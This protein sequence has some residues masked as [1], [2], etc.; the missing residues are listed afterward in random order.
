MLD[1]S[2]EKI[3]KKVDE[4]LE[5][6]RAVMVNGGLRINRQKTEYMWFCTDGKGEI[7]LSGESLERM[8]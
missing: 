4:T 2:I 5:N 8:K 7:R 3:T 1:V 6:L